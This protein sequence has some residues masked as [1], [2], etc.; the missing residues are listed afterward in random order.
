MKRLWIADVHATLPAFEA[1][2]ADAGEVDD[3]VFLGDIVD[4]GPHPSECID[5]LR[6]LD[7]QVVQGN[8]DAAILAI[9]KRSA[10]RAVP[11][12]WTEWTFDQLS[13]SQLS[14]LASM[15]TELSIDSCGTTIQAMHHPAGAP[16]LHPAMP[17]AVLAGHLQAIPY[18]VVFCGHSH[19]GIDRTVNGCRYV[20]IPSISQPRNGG[21]RAGYAVEHDGALEFRY[22]AYD[23]ERVAA[24]I[25]RIGLPE[26]FCQR[27]LRFLRT[28]FDVEWSFDY[29]DE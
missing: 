14:F 6:Q 15:P 7:A 19:R 2:V 18:A 16:Y 10:E 25:Q 4:F 8:H 1:V 29:K 26:K 3:I 20:C 13:E 21:P 23:V 27:W 22:V 28:G 5:L 9:G 11:L 12:S 17:D 24:D